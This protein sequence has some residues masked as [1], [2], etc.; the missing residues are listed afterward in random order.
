MN[1][2]KL[3]LREW[4]IRSNPVGYARSIGVK[5]GNDC[6]LIGINA[7]TFGTEPYLISIGD[8]VTVTAGVN[9][10]THDGGVWI[11]RKDNPDIDVIAPITVG[12]NVFIGL[13]A[14]IMPGVTIGDDCVIG[15]GAVVTRD[16]EPGTVVVGVPARPISNV[17]DYFKKI[18]EK[19]VRI[20]SLPAQ[21]KREM[22]EDR[23]RSEKNGTYA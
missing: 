6:R 7:Y 12:N 9:F 21:E 15:C 3:I 17:Q 2:F 23:F 16:V 10:V 14:I 8:H 19:A 18:D 22:L 5:I 1:P 4:K 11:F 13:R 20:R